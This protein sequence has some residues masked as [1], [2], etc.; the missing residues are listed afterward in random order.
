MISSRRRI[1][2]A[3][4]LLIAGAGLAARDAITDA[5]WIGLLWL[6]WIPLLVALWPDLPPTVPLLGRSTLRMTMIFLSIMALFA[7]QLLRVQVV[8][9]DSISHR[10]GIDPAT[11]DVISNPI[12][13]EAALTTLRG[14]IVDR[15]GIVLARSVVANG[16]THRAYLEP[17][18]AEV[19][20]YFSPLLYGASGLEA[21]WD[22]ELAGRAGGN[23]ITRALDDLRGLPPR[24]NDLHLTLDIALQRKAH[25]LLAGR[26]GAVVLLDARSGAVLALASEPSFDPNALV[27]VDAADRE[28]AMAAW[29]RLTSDPR[30]PLVQRATS[31]LFAPGSTFKTVTA[32][33]AIERG[34]AGPET[35]YEDDGELTIEGHTLIEANRPNDAVTEW[36]LQDAFSWSLNVV[37]AQIGL[38]IGSGALADAARGWGWESVI[39]FDLPVAPSR[40][41]VTPGFLD[42]PLAVAE[43]AFGQGELLAS[44]LQMALVASGVANDGEIMRPYLV[45]S[46]SGPDGGVLEERSPSRWRRGIGPEAARQTRALMVTAVENG[47]LGGAYVPGY[48]IGGKTGTAEAGSEN[49]HAWFIGFIGLPGEPPHY[50]VAVILESGGGGG[51]VALPIGRDMLVEAMGT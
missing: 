15:N 13:T 26:T 9:S 34:I 48:T 23:A 38:Q 2:G 40:V 27:A 46:I 44:P 39:P 12:L 41:S 28:P 18:A 37:F 30:N 14:A 42:A 51:Q 20:G 24:G 7:V 35:V 5:Q 22:D 50:A 17:A 49:P 33:A 29:S 19:T 16:V 21:S 1:A 10:A 43:T 36:T 31:G 47:A 25:D 11:G 4:F 6:S 3:L 45:A 32:A 8:M